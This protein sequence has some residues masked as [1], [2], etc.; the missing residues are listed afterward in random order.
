MKKFR[1][2]LFVAV[3]MFLV[4]T[5]EAQIS[6]GVKGGVNIS[7]VSFSSDIIDSE[8]VTGFHIG[9]MLELMVPF[10]NVGFDAAILYSQKGI[11]T[12]WQSLSTDN[13][14]V[15]VNFKWKFGV[16]LIK[17]YLAGG[18]YIG[19][20]VGG[21]KF[22]EAPGSV[23]NQIKA[24]SFGAGIN[25]GAGVEVISFLQVGFTYGLGLTD[26]YSIYKDGASAD[27]KNRTW[28][29]TAALLF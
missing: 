9:P 7:S 21:D 18:P 26:N 14:E 29:I 11:D 2:F 16:P 17:G 4:T 24:K 25:L 20:R 3:M 23:V 5:I 12:E 13:I 15:P 1:G 28:S 22:W 8:N 6:F 10:M 27:A 19:F